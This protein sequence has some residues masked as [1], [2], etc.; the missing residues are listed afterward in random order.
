VTTIRVSTLIAA[1][2]ARVWESVRDIESHVTWMEDAEAIRF[3]SATHTGVGTTFDCDTRVG[4]L[5]LTDHMEVTEWDE[6]RRMGIRHAGL[7]R[8]TGRFSIDPSGPG[9]V[10]TWEERLSFPLWLGGELVSR[11]GSLLLSRIWRRNLARLKA[12]VEG[13]P[14]VI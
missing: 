9:T 6:P 5:R 8:G 14:D 4:P 2:P 7:V 1:P 13:G 12:L 11:P 3:T 10:F